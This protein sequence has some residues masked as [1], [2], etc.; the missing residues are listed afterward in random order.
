MNPALNLELK[1]G[2]DADPVALVT[3]SLSDLQSSIDARLKDMGD[4]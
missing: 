3:K 4:C 2:N 1:D